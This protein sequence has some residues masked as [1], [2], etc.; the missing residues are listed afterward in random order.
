MIRGAFVSLEDISG[1]LLPDGDEI[2]S[3]EMEQGLKKAMPEHRGE[4][5]VPASF[6]TLLAFPKNLSGSG[7]IG[8]EFKP[9]TKRRE[10]SHHRFA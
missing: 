9:G 3:V 6:K 1:A 7:L 10:P 5:S 8:C 2:V 4:S